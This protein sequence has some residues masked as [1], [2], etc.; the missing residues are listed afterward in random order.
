MDIEL[1]EVGGS[2]RDQLLGIE[3]KDR[4]F[5]AICPQGWSRLVVWAEEWLDKVFLITPEYFTIRGIKD[6][7]VF[8]IVLARK[9]GAYSDG[10]HPDKVEPGTLLDDLARRDFTMNAIAQQ[11]DT[12]ALKPAA[13]SCCDDAILIDPHNGAQDIEEGIIR[14]VGSAHLRIKEDGLRI[15]R[16]LRFLITKPG[17]HPDEEL[18]EIMLSDKIY[19]RGEHGLTIQACMDRRDYY[20]SASGLL[21]SVSTDRIREELTKMFRYSTRGTLDVLNEINGAL[22]DAILREPIWL[23]PTMEKR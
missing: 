11:F 23:K 13:F 5:V 15:I 22:R 12:E 7:E 18:E 14:C 20:G 2:I 6:K 19:V 4:D 10:R 17:M 8:D 9:E 3:N 21:A 16:A 1:Y